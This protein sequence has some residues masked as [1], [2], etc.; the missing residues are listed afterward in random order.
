ME[1]EI[2]NKYR[3][4]TKKADQFCR[5]ESQGKMA[6]KLNRRIAGIALILVCALMVANIQQ[7][8][9]ANPFDSITNFFTPEK[10]TTKTTKKTKAPVDTE[11]AGIAATGCIAGAI[12]SKAEGGDP[13][14]GCVQ[15]AVKN[16]TEHDAR[17]E[18]EMMVRK[19]AAAWGQRI[20]HVNERVIER[21][22][23]IEKI[24]A[25][26][27]GATVTSDV[28]IDPKCNAS[29]SCREAALAAAAEA[30]KPGFFK[31]IWHWFF[32]AS[33]QTAEVEMKA[34]DSDI[35][36]LER[37]AKEI[38]EEIAVKEKSFS[39]ARDMKN[40]TEIAR[41]K[42]VLIFELSQ[43]T[44]TLT[45]LKTQRDTIESG[46]FGYIFAGF[47]AFFAAIA[48]K[49]SDTAAQRTIDGLKGLAVHI[50]RRI[51]PEPEKT[52]SMY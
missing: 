44:Q 6:Q 52:H 33:S 28:V 16:V 36:L 42:G 47:A 10:K 26:K 11:K 23:R 18:Q 31:S 39:A 12:L 17:A 19:D 2:A 13:S 51:R 25:E 49:M 20:D 41:E 8:N 30:A 24:S 50:R 48:K 34:I 35:D 29:D 7:A 40:K 38:K 5:T 9:A 1:N 14:Q 22:T 3:H 46:Y 32:P 37:S 21:Q 15:G 4:L 43:A 27:R 45:L